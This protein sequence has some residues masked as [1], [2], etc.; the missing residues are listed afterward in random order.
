[1]PVRSKQQSHLFTHRNSYPFS[2]S[3]NPT[4]TWCAEGKRTCSTYTNNCIPSYNTNALRHH[5]LGWAALPPI[6]LWPLGSLWGSWFIIHRT[7]QTS[8]ERQPQAGRG[9]AGMNPFHYALDLR[10]QHSEANAGCS[11]NFFE[12]SKVISLVRCAHRHTH[13]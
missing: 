2:P 9:L 10:L 8:R 11:V 5:W 7:S 13:I 1:M 12:S 4:P 3:F 6:H